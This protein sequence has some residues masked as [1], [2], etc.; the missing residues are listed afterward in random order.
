VNT[1]GRVFFK[2][3][4]LGDCVVLSNITWAARDFQAADSMERLITQ[5][6]NEAQLSGSYSSKVLTMSGTA[7]AMS[8]QS[9]DITTT[10]NSTHMDI[11]A[12]TRAAD[13]QQSSNCFSAANIDADFLENFE[14]LA[15]IASDKA[16]EA[17][18]WNPYVEFLKGN[19][20]HI[21]MQQLIGSRFQ[22]WESSTSTATDTAKMMQ[23]KACAQV[24]GTSIGG[25]W[26]VNTC[27]AY[28]SDEKKKGLQTQSESKR[29]ILG[30]TA[31]ARGALLKDVNK[32][33]LDAFI[34][35][36]EQGDQAVIF[37]FKPLWELL[38]G[39]YQPGCAAGG[40]DSPACKNLQRAVNLQAAFEGWTAVGCPALVTTNSVRYQEMKVS[41]T[42]SLG[43][44]TYECSVLKTGCRNGNDCHIGGGG[45]VCYCYGA[46]CLDTGD[47]IKGTP[48]NRTKVRGSQEGSYNQGVNNSC[49]FSWFSCGCNGGWSGG[50]ATRTLYQQSAP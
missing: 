14:S 19:G 12:A 37:I 38:Y 5:S 3:R 29:L 11:A 28:S 36:A 30:S 6:M 48:M 22:Q 24:E 21:M 34:D 45:S 32:V 10:F 49:D 8:G 20:S 26:S 50:L 15:L 47:P 23:V 16:S 31:A 17:A 25:G 40:K 27:G 18:S 1:G 33:N 7:Q 4:K 44:N 13:F 41:S 2:D 35:G 39:I 46:S 9:S 43:I 42:T